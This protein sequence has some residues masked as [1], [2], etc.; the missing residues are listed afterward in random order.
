MAADWLK[1][2]LQK[3]FVTLSISTF[4]WQIIKLDTYMS[5]WI[6]KLELSPFSATIWLISS[7]SHE[8]ER[9]QEMYH[10]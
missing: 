8:K 10:L 5:I 4:W 3:E 7:P 2:Q 9:R 1:D 6:R